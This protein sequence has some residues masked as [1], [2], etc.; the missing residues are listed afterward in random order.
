[1]QIITRRRLNEY[2]E[3]HPNAATSLSAWHEVAKNSAWASLQDVRKTFPH[4]DTAKVASGKTVTI[5]NIAGNHHRLITA[6]HYNTGKT[7]I[8]F[9]LTHADYSKNHWKKSL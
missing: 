1:M 4:A 9:I 5:F 6:I 7:F 3:L 8:L 2:G